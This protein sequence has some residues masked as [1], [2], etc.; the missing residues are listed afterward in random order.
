MCHVRA[1]VLPPKINLP[2]LQEFLRAFCRR[3]WPMVRC[4]GTHNR[5][6]LTDELQDCNY[7][8][9]V[10]LSVLCWRFTAVLSGSCLR[11]TLLA[12]SLTPC[13]SDRESWEEWLLMELRHRYLALC[14]LTVHLYTVHTSINDLDACYDPGCT[15]MVAAP[16][17]PPRIS[18]EAV[19]VFCVRV[20]VEGFFDEGAVWSPAAI[21]CFAMIEQLGL[22]VA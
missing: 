4:V 8:F 10:G 5:V 2:I 17:D 6:T 18:V 14:G 16:V 21:A 19:T 20:R 12:S 1:T 22:F 7:G 3:G 15:Y 9:F 13:W 11:A